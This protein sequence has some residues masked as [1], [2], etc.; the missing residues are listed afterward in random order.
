MVSL[1]YSDILTDI[2]N[3]KHSKCICPVEYLAGLKEREPKRPST[4]ECQFGP[5]CN[6]VTSCHFEPAKCTCHPQCKCG[7]EIPPSLPKLLTTDPAKSCLSWES[8]LT[9]PKLFTDLFSAQLDCDITRCT[10]TGCICQPQQ[11]RPELFPICFQ[12]TI[13]SQVRSK[14][15]DDL[16]KKECEEIKQ[17]IKQH[18]ECEETVKAKPETSTEKAHSEKEVKMATESATKANDTVKS[19]SAES[20]AKSSGKNRKKSLV[21][22]IEFDKETITESHRSVRKSGADLKSHVSKKETKPRR[23]KTMKKLYPART[24]SMAERTNY[25]CGCKDYSKRKPPRIR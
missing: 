18:R 2:L 3:R 21:S 7:L 8:D 10:C 24:K 4:A 22:P 16:M 17:L 19:N 13:K 1:R 14:V 5:N 20:E 25:Y 11:S 15:C 23:S 6:F 9:K 12:N